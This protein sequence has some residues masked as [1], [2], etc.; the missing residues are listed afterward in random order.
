MLAS[1][2]GN[3]LCASSKLLRPEGKTCARLQDVVDLPPRRP[4]L[5]EQPPSRVS[6]ALVPGNVSFPRRA[7]LDW[8]RIRVANIHS[9]LYLAFGVDPGDDPQVERRSDKTTCLFLAVFGQRIGRRC[10]P[11]Y[12]A[13]LPRLSLF[14]TMRCAEIH[15]GAAG[16]DRPGARN[17]GG[18]EPRSLECCCLLHHQ[19]FENPCDCGTNS[20]FPIFT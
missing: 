15:P 5:F 9:S 1:E 16:I 18:P 13:Y 8:H 19:A 3:Y 12:H 4:I 14:S 11:F 17:S 10:T 6:L 20:R 2:P 7:M